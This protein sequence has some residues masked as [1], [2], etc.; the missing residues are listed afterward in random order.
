VAD[1]NS[2]PRPDVDLFG[3]PIAPIR[4]RR[5]RPSF[6]KDKENQ[7]FVAIRA[8]AGWSQRRIA[9]NMGVDEKTLRKYFSRELEYGAVLTEG[10]MLDV[11]MK[12]VREGKVQ[13]IK[14]LYAMI[15]TAAPA[16]PRNHA[17]AEDDE[18][19]AEDK[20]KALGKKE[21][22]LQDAQMIPDDY[23]DIFAK[24]GRRH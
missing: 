24:M 18:P 17:D 16:A 2:E 20:P 15:K 12:L 6:K 19:E 10:V 21:Q 3:A 7:E 8:A 5:G 14:Q 11:L 4:D 22:A 1:E 9:E 13:A 23:G